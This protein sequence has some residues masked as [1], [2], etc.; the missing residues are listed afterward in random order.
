MH[1]QQPKTNYNINYKIYKNT[2]CN[3]KNKNK[4]ILI[5]R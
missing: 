3:Y 5:T 4:K 2:R 1:F